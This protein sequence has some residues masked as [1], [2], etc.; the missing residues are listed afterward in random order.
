VRGYDKDLLFDDDLGQTRT[1]AQGRFVIEFTDQQFRQV[2][3]QRPDV[4]LR[5][6]DAEGRRELFST[7]REVRRNAGEHEHFEIELPREALEGA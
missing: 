6:F 3:D 1:D 2:F 4:Y 5:V 7:R